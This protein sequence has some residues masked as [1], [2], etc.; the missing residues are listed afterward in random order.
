MPIL[1]AC[2]LERRRSATGFAWRTNVT[3]AGGFPRVQHPTA[4]IRFPNIVLC[5][6]SDQQIKLTQDF[7]IVPRNEKSFRCVLPICLAVVVP[8]IERQGMGVVVIARLKKLRR[9][10]IGRRFFSPRQQICSASNN[11]AQS[12]YD[13]YRSTKHKR[14][15]TPAD[16]SLP[17]HRTLRRARLH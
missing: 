2:S 5:V 8:A 10:Q 7:R 13:T 14:S 4:A 1:K 9:R 6:D 15:T 12:T 3:N 11:Q 16:S 17:P